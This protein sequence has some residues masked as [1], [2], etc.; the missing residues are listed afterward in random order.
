MN[1]QHH[2]SCVE[3]MFFFD[4]AKR[5]SGCLVNWTPLTLV[6]VG[7]LE[8]SRSSNIFME[9]R[10]TASPVLFHLVSTM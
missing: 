8:V 4:E 1:Q 10:D 5:V 9:R 2:Q 3:S 7:S 6:P